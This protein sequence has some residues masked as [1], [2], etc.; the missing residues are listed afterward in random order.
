MPYN[1]SGEK[2]GSYGLKEPSFEEIQDGFLVTFFKTTQKTT[3][4]CSTKD[5]IIDILREN[6]NLT[7]SE[8]AAVLS[9]ILAIIN[10]YILET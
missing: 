7:R 1:N 2:R 5:H 3:Q 6:P 8:S 4:K 9:N 10:A